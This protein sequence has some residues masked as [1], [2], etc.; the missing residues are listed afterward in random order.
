MA[1]KVFDILHQ[2]LNVRQSIGDNY[3]QYSRFNTITSYCML[4]FS[5]K[6]NDFKGNKRQG[7]R[8]NFE[9]FGPP[10]GTD[11]PHRDRGSE[12]GGGGFGR[13]QF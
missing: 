2:Q 1:L 11:R 6:I 12:G 3:I 10:D 8:Q 9:R 4:S 13:P 7:N 5:Y